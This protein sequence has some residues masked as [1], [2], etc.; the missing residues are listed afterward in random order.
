MLTGCRF[1]HLQH[2]SLFHP[3]RK[4]KKKHQG[5]K[6][7]RRKP[8]DQ[9]GG[10]GQQPPGSNQQPSGKH[11]RGTSARRAE[12]RKANKANNASAEAQGTGGRKPEKAGDNGG[13][14]RK[15]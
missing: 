6:Q 1:P 13:A 15:K 14:Q 11:E 9:K 12:K 4:R 2:L 7:E 10:G 5:T 3:N 8:R